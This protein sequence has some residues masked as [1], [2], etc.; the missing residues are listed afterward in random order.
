M[1]GAG[2]GVLVPHLHREDTVKQ[3]AVWVGFT[4][5]GQGG[6]ATLSGYF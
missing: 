5:S 6:A 4:P 3:R 1:A 2:I